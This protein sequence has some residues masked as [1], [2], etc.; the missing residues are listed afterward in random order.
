MMNVRSLRTEGVERK[1]RYKLHT[2][3][4]KQERK[5]TMSVQQQNKRE[6]DDY[7]DVYACMCNKKRKHTR[8]NGK[9]L[10]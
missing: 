10:L 8:N 9:K 1:L 6:I 5:A 3:S 7:S 4:R 2:M